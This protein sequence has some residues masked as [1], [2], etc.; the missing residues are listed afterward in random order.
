MLKIVKS[1]VYNY[2]SMNPA[3]IGK[4]ETDPIPEEMDAEPMTVLDEAALAAEAERI[5]Q[6]E[7]KKRIEEEI[8][9]RVRDIEGYRRAETE[10]ERK[11][12]LTSAAEEADRLIDDAKDR[13]R[14]AL[15][16]AAQECER[17]KEEAREEGYS[18]GFE[19]G[20]SEAMAQ[21]EKYL[22]AA[23]RFMGEINSRKE[24][25]Y[26]SHEYELCETVMAMVRKITLSEIRTDPDI[27]AK[28]A[29][30]AAK[31]FR[32]SDYI[33]ISLC[34]GEASKEFV[35][36]AE[37]VKS[38][39]PFIPE[40][41]VEEL[42]PEDVPQGTI[43]ID[44]GS[45]IIDASIPTQLDFLREIVRNA[46]GAGNDAPESTEKSSEENAPAAKAKR[47]SAK[48]NTDEEFAET[49]QLTF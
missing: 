26:I 49:E 45:E 10:A 16:A 22:E 30:A 17:L 29:A 37:F 41:E 46:S 8:S 24:A 18:A 27:I 2:D 40:I 5:R 34:Q 25:Y 28:I 7:E 39:I 13:T 44:N 14:T 3:V 47:S 43:V 15:E 48:K 33:K 42:S 21:C 35:T 23:A 20:K 36:D 1:R 6:E 32:N 9:R 19:A 12:I 4:R 11:R 38:I 31:G